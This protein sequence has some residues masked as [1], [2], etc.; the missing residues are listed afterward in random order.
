MH[1]IA[2]SFLFIDRTFFDFPGRWYRVLA[3]QVIGLRERGTSVLGKP[4]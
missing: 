4:A 3:G 1:I 2:C